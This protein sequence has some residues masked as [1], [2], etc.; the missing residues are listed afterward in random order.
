MGRFYPQCSAFKP[1]MY[2]YVCEFMGIKPTTFATANT[3]L[4]NRVIVTHFL[5]E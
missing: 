3:I 1:Y 4:Y 5:L 2:V